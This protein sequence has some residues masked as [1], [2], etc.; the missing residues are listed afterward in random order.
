MSTLNPFRPLFDDPEVGAQVQS[1]EKKKAPR[2]KV[3]PDK[4]AEFFA[5]PNTNAYHADEAAQDWI[6][7]YK[8][9]SK[10]GDTN[11]KGLNN[12]LQLALREHKKWS[13]EREIQPLSLSKEV[14]HDRR[15]ENISGNLDN[16]SDLF[17]DDGFDREIDR[18]GL[19]ESYNDLL[20][21]GMDKMQV[22]NSLR[23]KLFTKDLAGKKDALSQARVSQHILGIEDQS[24]DAYVAGAQSWVE[25][26]RKHRDEISNARRSAAENFF[27]REVAVDWGLEAQKKIS[28]DAADAY[29]KAHHGFKKKYGDIVPVV[30]DLVDNMKAEGARGLFETTEEVDV[31]WGKIME[32]YGDSRRDEF[33]YVL[34]KV[35]EQEGVNVDGFLARNAKGVSRTVERMAKAGMRLID[36]VKTEAAGV[37][38]ESLRDRQWNQFQADI[39]D[40][41]GNVARIEASNDFEKI[42]NFTTASLPYMVFAATGV[43]TGLI[44]ATEAQGFSENMRAENPNLTYAES[45]QVALPAGAVYAGIEK[46]QVGGLLGKFPGMQGVVNK[47]TSGK[48]L[49]SWVRRVAATTLYEYGQETFQDAVEPLSR[50]IA[51][52]FKAEVPEGDWSTFE[53][54]SKDRFLGVIG[55]SVLGGTGQWAR[56]RFTQQ[57]VKE[58]LQDK[59]SLRL[60]G[61]TLEEANQIAEMAEKDPDAALQQYKKTVFSKSVEERKAISESAVEEAESAVATGVMDG[62]PVVKSNDDGGFVVDF[63]DGTKKTVESREEAQVAIDQRMEENFLDSAQAVRDRMDNL[64]ETSDGDNKAEIAKP[65]TF[66][67]LADLGVETVERLKEAVAVSYM[68]R[69]EAAPENIDLNNY[70]EQGSV[71]LRRKMAGFAVRLAK[72]KMTLPTTVDEEFS[73]GFLRLIVEQGET[74]FDEV[75]T[76]LDEF[77]AIAGIDMTQ[78]YDVDPNRAVIEG[79]S[80]FAKAYMLQ[81]DHKSIPKSSQAWYRKAWRVLE[82]PDSVP[83]PLRA[84]AELVTKLL[85]S[86]FDVAQAIKS[87]KQDGKGINPELEGLA[88]RALGL[89]EQQI[90]EEAQ[91][92]YEQELQEELGLDP[93]ADAD[94]TFSI[95]NTTVTPNADTKTYPTKDGGVVG[96]ASFSITAHHG[97][98]H[99]VG[100]FSTENIGTG[101]GAQ[102]YGW[103]LYF[104]ES[105]E[106]AQQYRENLSN[107]SKFLPQWLLDGKSS[108]DAGIPDIIFLE[109]IGIDGEIETERKRLESRIRSAKKNSDLWTDADQVIKG[110]E[111]GLMWLEEN[112]D[113]AERVSYEERKGNLYQAEL[114]V[115]QDEL[116]D[117][118]KPLSEQSELVR[119]GLYE[120]LLGGKD[121]DSQMLRQLYQEVS[122]ELL[123]V[124]TDSAGGQIYNTLA[125]ESANFK[126]LSQALAAAGIKGIRYLDGDSRADGEGTSNY[127]IFNDADITITEENG[128]VVDTSSPSFSIT[129]A[130]DAEYADLAK[131][132]EKNRSALQKLVDNAAR[133]AGYAGPW[134][135]GAP[136]GVKITE[137]RRGDLGVHFGTREQAGFK[138]K[139]IIKTYI[140]EGRNVRVDSDFGFWMGGETIDTL[141][142]AGFDRMEL[143]AIWD[144]KNRTST[145]AK[146]SAN[147]LA[148]G[149]IELGID[150]ITYPNAFEG[151]GDSILVLNPNQAKSADPVTRDADGNVIPLS[152]RFDQS[153][154]EISFSI[155]PKSHGAPTS[156]PNGGGNLVAVHNLTPENLK[157][158]EE[159]FG[160]IPP[161]SI[162]IL[163]TDLSEFEGFGEI[164]LIVDPGFIDPADRDAKVWNADA[165]TP[166]FPQFVYAKNDKV[167]N[168][169]W[170]ELKGQAEEIGGSRF[171]VIPQEFERDGLSALEQSE[172]FQYAYLQEIG[173]APK[174]IKNKRPSVAPALSKYAKGKTNAFE[175]AADPEFIKLAKIE[176]EKDV[177][178]TR[179]SMQDLKR[180][181]YFT[182][183][184]GVIPM[185][186]ERLARQAVTYHQ[187][188]G[189]DATSTRIAINKRIESHRKNFKSWIS[190][191]FSALEQGKKIPNGFTPMGNRKFLPFNLDNVVKAMTRNVKAGEGFN[192]GVGSIRAAASKQF[193]SL[194]QIKGDREKIV[195]TET[196][197]AFKKEVDEEFS[198][199][200]EELA[201]FYNF[202]STSFGYYEQV[203]EGMMNLA[204]RRG[205]EWR[206]S[207]T[208]VDSDVMQKVT[209]FLSKLKNAPTEYFEVKVMDGVDVGAFDVAVVPKKTDSETKNLLKSKG[210]KIRLY[211][212]KIKGDRQR[213]IQGA[214]DTA[215]LSFSITP[216][217]EKMS[218]AVD[219]IFNGSARFA[220]LSDKVRKKKEEIL[221]RHREQYA[222]AESESERAI[223]EVESLA[224][225]EGLYMAL[226]SSMKAIRSEIEE[227]AELIVERR[228][229]VD[230]LKMKEDEGLRS[231]VLPFKLPKAVSEFRIIKALRI[232]LTAR[233][234]LTRE[235]HKIKMA[236]EATQLAELKEA[237]QVVARLRKQIRKTVKGEI[238]RD[239]LMRQAQE[240]ATGD[241]KM[242]TLP[243]EIQPIVQEARDQVDR[244]SQKMIDSGIAKGDLAKV[245]ERQMGNYLN[246][247]YRRFTRP[248]SWEKEVPQEARDAAKEYLRKE[249]P[250]DAYTPGI[251][252]D[253]QLDGYVE[254]LLKDSVSGSMM[255]S[256]TALLGQKHLGNLIGRKSI[257]KPIRDLWGEYKRLDENYLN[258]VRKMAGQVASHS[259]LEDFKK[260]GLGDIIFEK[261]RKGFATPIT[262]EGNDALAPLDGYHVS[263]EMAQALKDFAEMGKKEIGTW[264]KWWLKFN[265]TAKVS[266]TIYNPTTHA[267]NFFSNFGYVLANDNFFEY[268]RSGKDSAVINFKE[269][270][271]FART[272]EIEDRIRYYVRLG[273]MHQGAVSQEFKDILKDFSAGEVDIEEYSQKKLLKIAKAPLDVIQAAYQ[274]EDD[275]HKIVAFESEKRKLAKHK[276]NWSQEKIDREA[277]QII[278]DTMPD[279][280]QVPTAVKA[281][282][283]VPLIGT[284]TSFTAEVLRNNHNIIARA[285]TEMKDPDLKVVGIRRM[286]FFMMA[287]AVPIALAATLKEMFDVDDEEDEATRAIAAPWDKD[288]LLMYV[289]RSPSGDPKYANFSYTDP[290]SIF[291]TPFIISQRE[292]LSATSIT[293]GVWKGLEPFYGV[294]IGTKALMEAANNQDDLGRDISNDNDDVLTQ[295]RD[296]SIHVI[297]AL[298]PGFLRTGERIKRA[299]T[300]EK[301]PSG[302]EFDLAT[303]I[304]AVIT[305]QRV[306]TVSRQD[307]VRYRTWDFTD[308]K[309]NAST[310]FNKAWRNKD[311]DRDS[312]TEAVEEYRR[313]TQL[314]FE[315]YQDVLRAVSVLGLSDEEILAAGYD[316]PKTPSAQVAQSLLDAKVGET[317]IPQ[318]Q[319]SKSHLKEIREIEGREKLLRELIPEAF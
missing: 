178:E 185:T 273:I 77:G 256:M 106:L 199:L 30:R 241:A 39:G 208:G 99:K 34:G 307:A 270:F 120:H 230:S 60:T 85:R 151:K 2:Y 174:V 115:E 238:A 130:Q 182:A 69:G 251:S 250:A 76:M 155:T 108:T 170:N 62:L 221:A 72:D 9:T 14:R 41:K 212:P 40:L 228:S 305:G 122:T 298:E 83:A 235:Q 278:R 118:D 314:A 100:K 315:G 32:L 51:N 53:V 229:G 88:M 181:R 63:K 248:E 275:F 50:D 207:F 258:S 74:T 217:D 8:V 300:G 43:G 36:Q 187:A 164:S 263:E 65:R 223:I 180:E 160:V 1:T 61:A 119:E 71:T 197:E 215:K 277:A 95:G 308:D 214:A 70:T 11:P 232:N 179:K 16:W 261:P 224:Q 107:Q 288:S 202:D 92:Q 317:P 56:D 158:A 126:G 312:L 58:E 292:G 163:R 257:P 156:I 15:I 220:E 139:N 311:A 117:W 239:M 159:N 211:D 166:R 97:T 260:D 193:K 198:Q 269:I 285:I 247:S 78:G 237:E 205:S 67:E 176:L 191:K 82:N 319:F 316:N 28:S 26:R 123:G 313:D 267:R 4:A 295:A 222:K 104:A 294:E 244:L 73:E 37:S 302:K 124:F 22:Q 243:K 190:E 80:K 284:F 253:E 33:L 6:K 3:H 7:T 259:I 264:L 175:L 271:G 196:M 165:Y 195:S 219:Q 183:D 20:G 91:A 279:Y 140:D 234:R 299:Y 216:K 48:P 87:Q 135:H 209:D 286:S 150:S 138:N 125:G 186:L 153:R 109:N 274:A 59:F 206:E 289:G 21:R 282:R 12:R 210:L 5:D 49:G 201:P 173:K 245:F 105:R 184:G 276:K 262:A 252:K 110:A 172:V 242:D 281:L 27:K 31:N 290:F 297:K 121:E 86:V 52:Q 249:L 226:P 45:M 10:S 133:A 29:S 240:V 24:D 68:Q 162:A 13:D 102:A 296:R 227:V 144:K 131:N 38:N 128:K 113:A 129:P 66:Q 84:F 233:G 101:E 136:E 204:G 280:S 291:K 103:G 167:A 309:R 231:V 145:N 177:S 287:H 254:N 157:F 18:R 192:Y 90:A 54:V 301:T 143:Q 57:E 310:N 188:V 35:S 17:S 189:V 272:P 169:I 146:E 96:P 218:E 132:P 303:E 81:G 89:N 64:L 19:A 194:K 46:L 236:A 255:D 93:E 246:R 266:K 75:K 152:Q 42:A 114:N 112:Q 318:K 154:G 203:A 293:K 79:F 265:S 149:L 44:A 111:E 142:R 55:L 141:E 98:P 116:L 213:V 168:E 47:F 148:E 137:F 134:F 306:T 268:A 283:R 147:I 304:G 225:A 25:G 127:V 161:P 94:P 23:R 200:T 171:D